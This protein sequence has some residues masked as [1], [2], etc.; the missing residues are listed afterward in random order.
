MSRLL[1]TKTGLTLV[2]M[3]IA[4]LLLSIVFLGVSSLCVA[5]QKFYFSSS[6]NVLIGYELQPAM[7][8]IYE[9]VM[10]GIGDKNDPPITVV[11]ET[12]FM[13]NYI[14]KFDGT[15]KTGCYRITTNGKLEF[16]RTDDGIFEESFGSTS[17]SFMLTD[18]VT[19]LKL[20]KFYMDGNVLKTQLTAE[21]S[22]ARSGTKKRS[23]LYAACYPRLA[24]FR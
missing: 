4:M 14:D 6:D 5:S 16:D 9:H 20:S 15:R 19:G 22:I 7:Q 1:R 11:S 23:T 21:F 2:E 17:V 18:P 3:M 12:E 10:L 13:L 24:S 8:H